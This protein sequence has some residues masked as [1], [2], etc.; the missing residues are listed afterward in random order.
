[1]AE[2]KIRRRLTTAEYFTEDLGGVSLEMAYIPAGEFWMGSSNDELDR[3]NRDSPQHFVK[4]PQFF[5]GKYPVTQA[6][7]LAVMGGENPSYFQD[8]FEKAGN[9]LRRPVETVSWNDAQ[10]FCER[11]TEMTGKPYQLPSEAQWEYACRGISSF[12]STVTSDQLSEEQEA[13]LI[14]EWN[15]NHNQPFHWGKTI[16]DELAN[17][18]ATVVYGDGV[19]GKQRGETT[20]VTELANPNAFGLSD[21]HGNV[22]EW[23]LD[24]WHD[25]YDGAPTDG[26]AWTEGGDSTL[27]VNRG[28]SWDGS[29]RYCRSACRNCSAPDYRDFSVGFRVVCVP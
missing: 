25:N 15:E 1:M 8:D 11:L 20:P 16:T 12:Q 24:H 17:Y 9:A 5:M 23:C 21:M 3:S 18:N 14:R 7:W 13:A 29:P 6:Q 26:S 28:G 19:E 2:L 4:V 27:R 10:K 22:R